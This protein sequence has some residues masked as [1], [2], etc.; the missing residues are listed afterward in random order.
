MH[1]LKSKCISRFWYFNR[2]QFVSICTGNAGFSVGPIVV[3]HCADAINLFRWHVVIRQHNHFTRIEIG[4]N[5]IDIQH[6]AEG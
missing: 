1:D 2:K 6:R 4:V 3:R 5:Q